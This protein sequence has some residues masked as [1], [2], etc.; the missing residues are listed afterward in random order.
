MKLSWSSNITSKRRMKPTF[1]DDTE[2]KTLFI[3]LRLGLFRDRE[4]DLDK[5][6]IIKIE[7]RLIK[8]KSI[9]ALSLKTKSERIVLH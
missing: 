5:F 2:N 3:N 8:I 6:L 7:V 9:E 1:Y 4:R